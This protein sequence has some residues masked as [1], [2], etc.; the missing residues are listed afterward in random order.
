MNIQ[1]M[2]ILACPACKL[3]LKLTATVESGDDVIEGML[4]CTDCGNQ[5][6]I[7]DSVP[8]LLLPQSYGL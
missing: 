3:T 8:N 5:Y 4:L 6:P 7:V 1:L 2:E